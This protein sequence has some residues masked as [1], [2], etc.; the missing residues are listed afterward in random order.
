M[1]TVPVLYRSERYQHEADL[2]F[3]EC[4]RQRVKTPEQLEREARG[5]KSAEEARQFH[6]R[7]NK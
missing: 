1:E 6:A 2:L 3:G 4:N 7:K 5:M